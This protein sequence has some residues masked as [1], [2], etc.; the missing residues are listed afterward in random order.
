MW[1]AGFDHGDGKNLA[2]DPTQ[3]PARTHP[4]HNNPSGPSSLKRTPRGNHGPIQSHT[5]PKHINLHRP[6]QNQN[7]QRAKEAQQKQYEN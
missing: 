3:E 7:H 6:M 4:T 5:R 2:S 1:C